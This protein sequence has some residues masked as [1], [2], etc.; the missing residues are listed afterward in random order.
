MNIGIIGGGIGG[1]AAAIDL[2]RAG[3]GVTIFERHPS[4]GGKLARLDRDGFVFD[5]GPTVLTMPFLLRELFESCGRRLDDYLTLRP[6]EPTCRYHWSDG[7]RFDAHSDRERLASEVARLAPDDRDPLFVFLDEIAALYEATKDIF[8]FNPFGGVAELFKPRNLRLL[9]ILPRLGVA[10]TVDA[11]LRRRFRSPKLVQLFDRFAT[12]NGSSPYRAS[13]TLNIIPHVELAFGSWY[14]EGGMGALALALERLALELGVELR[15]STEVERLELAGGSVGAI[16]ASGE[17]HPADA[18]ISNVDVLWTYR[19][20]LEPLGIP[21]PRSVSGAE[22]SCSGFL[23]LASVRG[24]HPGL[25]HHNVFFSD[26][27]PDEFRDIFERK[28]LP[29]AMTI[30]IS[31]ASKSDRPLAPE[32]C[33]GWYILINAPS[34]G[35][36]HHDPEAARLYAESVWSRLRAFGIEPE[37]VA[38]SRLTPIDIERR[39][40]S[41]GGAIYGASSNSIFSA[42]LRPGNRAPRPRGLYFCGGSAHPGGGIPLAL[43]SGRIAAGLVTRDLASQG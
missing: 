14:P 32:G 18:V 35:I 19:H 31:I 7:E 17:R 29:R 12:Y 22:R 4:M 24:E 39:Y 41:V 28:R 27:Y 2:R 1:L 26:D 20:L 38:Q 33:E 40:G 34:G 11:S 30:Y 16:I 15:R 42:F 37:V 21:A 3:L 23:I 25:A 5:L 8:L 9:P 13:A 36:E 43:L 6:V 10:T